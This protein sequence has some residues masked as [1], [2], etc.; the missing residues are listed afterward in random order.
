MKQLELFLRKSS[1][2]FLLRLPCNLS[3]CTL[4]MHIEQKYV[5]VKS[6]PSKFSVFVRTTVTL[7]VLNVTSNS[8]LGTIIHFYFSSWTILLPHLSTCSNIELKCWEQWL[9]H[10]QTLSMY[11][12]IHKHLTFEY[13]DNHSA[14]Q[15]HR[16]HQF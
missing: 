14:S 8:C 15:R 4:K 13:I 6:V 2:V 16:C 1:N 12:C 3:K 9:V 11:K 5:F 7:N 10:S